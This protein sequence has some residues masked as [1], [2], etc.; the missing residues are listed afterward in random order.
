MNNNNPLQ[1]NVSGNNPQGNAKAWVIGLVALIIVVFV[2]YM[3]T[4][5]QSSSTGML[6]NLFGGE[7]V[8]ETPDEEVV[9]GNGESD[10]K[11]QRVFE[12]GVYVTI[13]RY[14]G[15]HFI[16]DEITIPSG[17]AVR[18]VNESD[19]A[20]RVGSRLENLSSTQY[21][22]FAQTTSEGKGG[23]YQ[24]TLTT[25]GIWSY[26]NLTSR[27]DLQALGVIYVK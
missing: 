7:E 8:E 26:E 12:D 16:P 11:P 2:G 9:A 15:T 14:T 22:S 19:L 21:S 27:G 4:S 20:M 17:E 10:G 24:V 25:P 13:I 5:P 6:Q 18:F 3:L 1:E 23:E